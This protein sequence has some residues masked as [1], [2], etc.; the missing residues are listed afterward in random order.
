MISYLA[1]YIGSVFLIASAAVLALQ[2]LSEA[3]DNIDRYSLL[4]KIGVDEEMIN[5]SILVQIAI[6]FMIPL[7]L[8]IVHSIVGLKISSDIVSVFG[9]GSIMNYII[10][11]MIIMIII[12]G[13]YFIAAYNGAKKML[14]YC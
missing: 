11:T 10:V 7:S 2:Q 4:R 8:A 14:K 5:R 13:G 12:Y 6:Y 3:A 1:I 9:D